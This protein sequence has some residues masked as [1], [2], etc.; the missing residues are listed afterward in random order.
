[1]ARLDK[2]L[3]SLG[4]GSRR[5]VASLC[6]RGRVTDRTGRPLTK[7]DLHI[8]PADILFDR[9]PLDHP[10]GVFIVMHK[11]LGVTCSHDRREGELVYDL[12]PD[13]WQTRLPV[14]ASI[15]R[16]DKETSGVLVLTDNGQWIHKL[17]SPKHHIE[18]TY[19][20]TTSTPLDAS[21]IERFA[22]GTL[23]LDGETTPCLPAALTLR[24]P[25]EAELVV[26]EG[27]YH[28]VRRMF[29]ACGHHVESLH[30]S[31]FGPYH[32]DD[33]Q[34]GE[35]TDVADPDGVSYH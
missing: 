25:C 11:P 5:D 29:A 12:L 13:R 6:Q 24:G 27:R 35:W 23:V 15:G 3:S 17:A 22:S 7:P 31:R 33:L 21:L 16:L 9:Q 8:K 14:V 34:P 1:M 2:V 28:Q 19:L 30:R 32:C 18:K 20:A 10:D 26:T 4:Y